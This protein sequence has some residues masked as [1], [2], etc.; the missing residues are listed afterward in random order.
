MAELRFLYAHK[1]V[2]TSPKI[3][4]RINQKQ[5]KHFFKLKTNQ[6]Y[7]TEF[8]HATGSHAAE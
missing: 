8:F 5:F 4:S 1:F 3:R 2:Q 6:T 7:E